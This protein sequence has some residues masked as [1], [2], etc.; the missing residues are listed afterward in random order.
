MADS[1]SPVYGGGSKAPGQLPVSQPAG[2]Y[3][4]HGHKRVLSV[5]MQ[6]TTESFRLPVNHAE[7]TTL[8]RGRTGGGIRQTLHL[9][10]S[11]GQANAA[12]QVLEARVGVQA[13]ENRL[14]LKVDQQIVAFLEALL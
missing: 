12:H 1:S 2:N 13:I 10:T 9:R 11:L 3:S 4:I 5:L 8:R 7:P 14:N 6:P